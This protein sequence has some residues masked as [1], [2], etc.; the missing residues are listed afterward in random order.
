L[1]WTFND[2]GRAEAGYK[3]DTG[4]CACRSIAIVTGMSYQEVYDLI[5]KYAAKERPGTRRKRSHPRTGVHG[6]TLRKIMAD[7]GWTWVPTMKI[8]SGTTVHVREGEL[9]T[10]GKYLLRLSRHFCA[11]VD[12]VVHDTYDPAREGTR[13]VYGF[14]TLAGSD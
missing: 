8:G 13:A 10:E 5:I 11:I 3:G 4:D 12:G 6:S 14:W 7:L 9:P 2:G 1:Q